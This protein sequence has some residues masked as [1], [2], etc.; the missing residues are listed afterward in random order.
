M[1]SSYNEETR[2]L[3]EICKSELA[4]GEKMEIGFEGKFHGGNLPEETVKSVA[5]W[6][7]RVYFIKKKFPYFKRSGIKDRKDEFI[8]F[9]VIFYHVLY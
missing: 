1:V 4:A 7:V 6:V 9:Y 8:L 5:E 2:N 3:H